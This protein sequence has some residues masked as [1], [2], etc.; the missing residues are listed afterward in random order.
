MRPTYSLRR[1]RG[2]IRHI[3]LKWLTSNEFWRP[4]RTND[5]RVY[6]EVPTGILLT[7]LPP[8]TESDAGE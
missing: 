4:S 3:G 6:V 2:S 5:E 7:E 1:L 8:K